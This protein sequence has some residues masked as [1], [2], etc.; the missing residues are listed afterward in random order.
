MYNPEGVV[1]PY[2][3]EGA[4]ALGPKFAIEPRKLALQMLGIVHQVA[5]RAPKGEEERCIAERLGV[6]SLSKQCASNTAVKSVAR[7]LTGNS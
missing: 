7:F 2:K 5:R 1:L 4:L 3:V 6:L